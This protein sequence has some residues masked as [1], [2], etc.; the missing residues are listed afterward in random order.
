MNTSGTLDSTPLSTA[1]HAPTVLTADIINQHEKT[2]DD[3][4]R[5]QTEKDIYA[6]LRK[7]FYNHSVVIDGI[8]WGER[9]NGD[10][11]EPIRNI[12]QEVEGATAAQI[13]AIRREAMD[14]IGTLHK[15][16]AKEIDELKNQ[17]VGQVG[18]MTKAQK[19]QTDRLVAE[20]QH[21]ETTQNANVNAAM[22]ELTEEARAEHAQRMKSANATM[23]AVRDS[24]VARAARQVA[25]QKKKEKEEAIH[26]LNMKHDAE[27]EKLRSMNAKLTENNDKTQEEMDKEKEEAQKQ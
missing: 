21:S 17:H 16:H 14:A 11:L 27:V 8:L 19:E 7:V 15:S 18:A 2:T 22:Q 25:E 3:S 23:T 12:A 6:N 26:K 4:A 13:A 9:K 20:R 24:E 5:T 10:V 1:T